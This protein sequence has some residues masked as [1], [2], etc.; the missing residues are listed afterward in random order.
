MKVFNLR[1][2]SV[3]AV[4][5][6]FSVLAVSCGKSGPGDMSY[7][8]GASGDGGVSGKPSSP[9]GSSVKPGS[10]E[11]ERKIIYTSDITA[12]TKDFDKACAE[13]ERLISEHLGYVQSSSVT[14]N[15]YN[16][17]SARSAKYT[18]R[19]P[20][21]KYETFLSLFGDLINVTR[22]QRYSEDITTKYYDLEARLK[23]LETERANL[24]K[25]LAEATDLN[26]MLTIQDKLY[27]VIYEI[28]SY[29]ATMKQYELLTD[30]ATV[31]LTL[32]E[33]VEYSPDN[34]GEKN[35]FEKLWDSF[36][37]SWKDFGEGCADFSIW[38][39]GAI[40]TLLVIA[41]IFFVVIL[42]IK[43]LIMPG[44]R[45]KNKKTSNDGNDTG[46]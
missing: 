9:D 18:I 35:Y 8:D 26:N 6:L 22:S 29:T 1:L 10:E 7:P 33:V 31:N 38:L 4:I 17:H 15:S 2:V 25:M 12:E 43:K 13:I 28:E 45:K 11:L 23:T 5:L 39:V 27:D 3:I 30:Y 41:A 44:K 21:D 36:K 40:P 20:A 32:Y 34:S 46:K 14:G 37:T 42:I 19:I 16:N 24:T